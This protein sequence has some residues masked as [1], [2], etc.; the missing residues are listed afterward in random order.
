MRFQA[1]IVTHNENNNIFFVRNFAVRQ[2]TRI[3]RP[4]NK[5]KKFSKYQIHAPR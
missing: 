1:E 3:L 2:N 4:I 5:K